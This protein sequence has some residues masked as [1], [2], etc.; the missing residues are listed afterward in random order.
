MPRS[1]LGPPSGAPDIKLVRVS[2]TRSPPRCAATWIFCNSMHRSGRRIHPCPRADEFRAA[3][4]CA[5]PTIQTLCL[6]CAVRESDQ[7]FQKFRLHRK[8]MKPATPI[9]TIP[10]ITISVRESWRASMIIAPSPVGTPVISPTTMTTHAKPR[11]SRRPVKMAG[12]LAGST[13]L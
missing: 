7:V 9:T 6:R 5:G 12:R 2:A 11:P 10:Q 8:E 3:P 4:L 1:G 13:T